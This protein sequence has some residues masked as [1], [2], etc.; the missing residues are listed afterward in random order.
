MLNNLLF[1]YLLISLIEPAHAFIQSCTKL[2][3]FE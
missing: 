3:L 2:I 1:S